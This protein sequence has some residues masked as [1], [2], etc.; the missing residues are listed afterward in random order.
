MF[1]VLSPA[2]QGEEDFFTHVE[3]YASFPF[4]CRKA[5]EQGTSY[6]SYQEAI[7]F[8]KPCQLPQ[9]ATSAWTP[10][11]RRTTTMGSKL[12]SMLCGVEVSGGLRGLCSHVAFE[13]RAAALTD[14]TQFRD[15]SSSVCVPGSLVSLCA[16]PWFTLTQT[17]TH[18]H[19]DTYTQSPR[20]FEYVPDF[21]VRF[22]YIIRSLKLNPII[23]KKDK[24]TTVYLFSCGM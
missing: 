18:T 11:L 9:M 14:V 5:A 1:L 17:D 23:L 7:F 20:S 3:R 10:C 8:R 12:P 15:C 2:S 24:Q 4:H 22:V 6:K 16:F 19:T 13:P 21:N